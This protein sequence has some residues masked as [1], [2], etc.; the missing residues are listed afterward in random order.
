MFPWVYEFH[1]SLGHVLFLGIFFSVLS[2]VILTVIK[3]MQKTKVEELLR[4]VE[5]IRWHSDFEDLPAAARVC[6]H[7]LTG[8]VQ[9]RTCDHGFD[10]RTCTMHPQLLLKR[11]NEFHSNSDDD[12]FGFLMPSDRMYHRGHT[13]VKREAERTYIIGMDDF[14]KRLIGNAEEIQLPEI[15]T[16]LKVNETACTVKR[17]DATLRILSP[18]D[19]EVI[20]RTNENGEWQLKVLADDSSLATNHL[21]HESEIRPW[22][23]R[24]MERLQISFATQKIGAT[25][26]DG[27][28]LVPDF[29]QRFP[30]ADW[31]GILGH[32]FLQA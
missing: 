1:W 2:I 17:L 8:E 12:V 25:L 3:A 11:K 14:G 31:D 18:L 6:R 7:E 22:I 26:A 28:E 27:G 16:R 24:E 10:C 5:K 29:H 9:H 13:Y 23:M 21:L 15:G 4:N 20:E 32:M 30:K 19:G